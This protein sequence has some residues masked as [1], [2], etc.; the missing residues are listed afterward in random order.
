MLAKEAHRDS[1]VVKIDSSHS[2]R[3]PQGEKY[4]ASGIRIA[5]RLWENEAPG[6]THESTRSYETVS[7]VLG[8]RAELHIE[9]QIVIL[10]A[11]DSYVVPRGARHAFRIV[12]P[13]TAVE[14]TTPPFQVHGRDE[15]SRPTARGLATPSSE[16]E[17]DESAPDSPAAV[18]TDEVPD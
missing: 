11:G 16:D 12:Q 14:A 1:T 4:L 2:P 3:G 13:F 7:Y 17:V 10:V 9:G 6:M 8:G 15:L 5:M 18:L